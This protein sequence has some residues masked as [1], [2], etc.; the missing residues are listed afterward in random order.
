MNISHILLIELITFSS[1]EVEIK[2]LLE[3]NGKIRDK[4][5]LF[6]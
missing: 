1:D 5:V 2:L 6:S 4:F 3:I